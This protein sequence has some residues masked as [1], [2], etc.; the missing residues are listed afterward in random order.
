MNASSAGSLGR[1]PDC[2]YRASTLAGHVHVAV[3]VKVH[4]Q[5]H[6]HDHDRDQV[7]ER[8]GPVVTHLRGTALR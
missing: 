5:V 1:A 2:S 3:A 8:S 7:N 4:V 6:D